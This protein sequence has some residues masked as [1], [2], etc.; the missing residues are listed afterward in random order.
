MEPIRPLEGVAPDKPTQAMIMADIVRER[1][2]SQRARETAPV[3]SSDNAAETGEKRSKQPEEKATTPGE[4][5]LR[6][7]YAEFDIN[8]ETREV[9]VRIFDGDTGELVRVI[10]PDELARE[11]AAGNLPLARM[12]RLTI[13]L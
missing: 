8:Q 9:L 11:I 12:R 10:P 2:Y 3:E 7:T 1:I 5:G 4:S 13:H 6:H